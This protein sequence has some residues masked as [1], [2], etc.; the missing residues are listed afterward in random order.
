MPADPPPER[1][2][3]Y[4]ITGTLGQGGMGVVYRAEQ[5][6]PV[7][8]VAL[9]VIKPG[10]DSRRVIAR[11]KAEMQ[12]MALMDHPCVAKIFDSG[13]TEDER[14]YFVMEYVPGLPITKHCEQHD[15]DLDQRLQLFMQVC[16]AVQHGHQKGIIHRDIKPGNVLVVVDGDSSLPKVIDFG[17]AKALHHALTVDS[18]IN[19][20]GQL[21]GTPEY[22]SPEQ[23]AMKDVDTRSDIYSL[24]VMLYELLTGVLPF[25]RKSLHA[26]AFAEILR[27]VREVDPPKPSTRVSSLGAME[28]PV[29][30]LSSDLDD[31][32]VRTSDRRPL[33]RRLRGD[34]DWITMKA[35]EKDP[36]HRY[37]SASELAADIKR[38]LTAEP[39]EAAAPGVAYRMRK[40]VR[41]NKTLVAATTT[42]A[43]A[44]LIGTGVSTWQ[45]IRASN[46]SASNALARLDAE[47]RLRI[48]T[49]FRLTAQAQSVLDELPVQSLL[50]P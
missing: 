49:A 10:M 18:L 39:I 11:F 31:G 50:D 32:D 5:T 30:L 25:D 21:I 33:A 6:D 19:D 46:L 38:H 36:A 26:A 42:I 15:L 8:T 9:K 24:G 48:E 12:A 37:L 41:R 44:L 28:H 7:R 17:V 43:F 45:A 29:D 20:D 40:F 35:L 3:K 47:R 14:P 16:D 13:L 1:I 2:G 23:A 34:L 4:R 22:M 27:I